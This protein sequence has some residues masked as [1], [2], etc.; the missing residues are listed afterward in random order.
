MKTSGHQS[1]GSD[2]GRFGV[3]VVIPDGD[4]ANV[5][6]MRSVNCSMNAMNAD[7]FAKVGG[8]ACGDESGLMIGIC[9]MTDDHRHRVETSRTVMNGGDCHDDEIHH[10]AGCECGL[11]DR[12]SWSVL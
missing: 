8:D 7:P 4:A 12:A 10:A 9:E 1:K 3:R 2:R 6:M 11:V 5:T